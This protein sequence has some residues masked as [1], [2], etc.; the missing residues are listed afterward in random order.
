MWVVCCLSSENN[1]VMVVHNFA[2]GT[3]HIVQ[4]LKL[5]FIAMYIVQCIY[6]L[7]QPLSHICYRGKMMN[8]MG[9]SLSVGGNM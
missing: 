8:L 1:T 2:E 4:N 9:C 6:Q 5:I 7:C 3:S